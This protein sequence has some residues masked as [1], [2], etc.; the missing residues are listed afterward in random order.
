MPLVEWDEPLHVLPAG[1]RPE[2]AL[3]EKGTCVLMKAGGQMEAVKE[4]LRDS[5]LDVHMVENCGMG[6][7]R[8][9]HGVDAIPEDAEY[10]S[11]IIVK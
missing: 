11:T 1:H 4:A 10:F 3:D 7:E 8:S 9:F 2:R 5:G 6:G